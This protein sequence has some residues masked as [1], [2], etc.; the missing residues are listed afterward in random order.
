MNDQLQCAS[1]TSSP[2]LTLNVVILI[3]MVVILIVNTPISMVITCVLVNP[4]KFL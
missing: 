4:F 1:L 2:I 3:V